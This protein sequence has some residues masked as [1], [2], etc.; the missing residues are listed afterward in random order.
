M[1]R[2]ADSEAL[3]RVAP[4]R[5]VMRSFLRPEG[6]SQSIWTL[7][8][9][10]VFVFWAA[11]PAE[12]SVRGVDSQTAVHLVAAASVRATCSVLSIHLLLETV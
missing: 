2:C 5:G 11:G 10:C 6:P 4:W 1:Y 8:E 7:R 9:C 12:S 3:E